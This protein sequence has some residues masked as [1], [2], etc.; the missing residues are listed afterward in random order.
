MI[1][2][3][4]VPYPYQFDRRHTA[5]MVIDM[6]RD[7]IEAGGFGSMLG[8][9]VR[10]LARIVPT[11]AQL[12]TLARAQRMWVVHTR[13][14][15]LPDLS[16]CPPA[17]RRRG[18]PAL[19][20]GDA[21]P[22]GRILVRGAPGNQILPLLAPLDGELV[23]RHGSDVVGCAQ[24]SERS[25]RRIAQPIPSVLASDATPR[26]ASM[27]SA[28]RQMIGDATL[29]IDKPGK[30]AF[31]AT[32]LHAQ[33]QARGITHLL[34]AGVTTE[35]C[36]QTSMR[37]ANDRG[38]ES[39]IVEDACASYFRAFHLATLAMLTAQG[40]IVGWKAPLALLQ[41]AFKKTAGESA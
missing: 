11:V 18:N 40:G 36:V 38:Y 37:E 12:L 32:D 34:F 9:D 30:G 31:H 16:D 25:A 7:F 13:E 33:L 10:P 20:I 19:A 29:V 1:T 15:H 5:L 3:D 17:K 22:M 27:A 21:G 28:D 23:S 26:C 2:V 4:A 39:L 35:V 6:Q 41:A 24:P 14:S 8:N